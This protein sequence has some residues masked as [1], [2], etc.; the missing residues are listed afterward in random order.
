MRQIALIVIT[1][2]FSV[3]LSAQVVTTLPSLVTENQQVTIVFDAT[4][5]TAGLTDYNGDVYAHTG[6]I[7]D[8]STSS[9]DWKYVLAAWT[10]NVDKAKMVRT[11]PNRYTL[12][13]TPDIRQFYGVPSGEKILKLAFVFRSSDGSKE[14]K[15][16]GG[17]DILVDVFDAGL[18]VAI[19][20]PSENTLILQANTNFQFSASSTATADLHL[21]QNNSEIKTVTGTQLDNTFNFAQ[22]GDYWL[23]VV[24]T[25]ATKRV[26]DSVFVNVL[27]G[28][29]VQTVP[30]GAKKGINYIDSQTARLVLWAPFKSYVHVIGEFNDWIPATAFRMKR[31]GD[32]FW[33]DIPNLTPGKEYPFQYLV[34]GN[35]KIADPYTEKISDPINDKYITSVTYPG[36]ISYPVDRGDGIMSVLQTNQQPYSWTINSYKATTPD[37]M[38]VYE[39]LVRDFDERHSYAGVIDHLDYLKDLGVNVLELMPVNEFEGNSSWG[40][41]PSFYFAPDKYYGPKNDLKRL[42]DECHKRNIAVVTDLVLNHSFGQSPFVQLYFDGSK[43]TTQNPWYNVQSNFTNPDAQWGYDFNHDSQATRQL[44][45]SIGS[46]WMSEYKID[47]FRYDFTKGFSNSIKDSSDPWGSKY[48]AQRVS[49]LERM[50]GEIWKRK[51]SALVIFEHLADNSEEKELAG[52]GKGILLWGNMSGNAAEAAMGYNENG[53]SDLGWSSYAN[54]GW[55]KPSLVGY[56]ESHDEER[57]V[58]KCITYG[59]TS[60]SYNIKDLP[61]ALSRAALTAA[62]FIPVPGPKMIWQ[63]GELGYDISI[64]FNGR[65][66][67][68]PLHWD[69]INNTDRAL[70]FQ[71]FAKLIYLKKKYPVFSTTDFTQS[72]N[73]EIKWLKLNLN[74]ENVL[75]AGNFG[76]ASVSA[77]LD[78]QKTGI[79][80]DYFGQKSLNVTATSQSILLAPGEYKVYSTQNY[81]AQVITDIEDELVDTGKLLIGPNPATDYIRVK[82]EQKTRSISV[83]NILGIK[84]KEFILSNVPGGEDELYIGDLHPGIYFLQVWNVDGQTIIR[85]LIKRP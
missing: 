38:V 43:P 40:Y 35:L 57:M 42:V 20:K 79:W 83:Y 6:V 31:D 59:N 82:S 39:C 2:L 58:Y 52:F 68:K 75:I 71:V 27:A 12:Q 34:D 33:I 8:K 29:I 1:V 37:T 13:L 62:L 7:T 18:N 3:R 49:N 10:V 61:V 32:Y 30:A 25:N 41:N 48:D 85:K 56:M 5:G 78:F 9:S 15:D 46:F 55:S 22:P 63:F 47:G 84:T 21:F 70:L 77:V 23:K 72:L 28:Q 74:G 26:A 81:G 80:Y 17:K 53:K 66:G 60:G 50:A 64:D 19:T 14:G 4:K 67:E 54:R 44:V 45:D 24:A 76:M 65:T 16:T 51:P 73:G 69:Y 36:L 11:A